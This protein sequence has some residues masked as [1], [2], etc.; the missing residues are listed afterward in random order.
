MIQPALIYL[1]KKRVRLNNSYENIFFFMCVKFSLLKLYNKHAMNLVNFQEKKLLKENEIDKKLIFEIINKCPSSF[2]LF[3]FF[4]QKFFLSQKLILRWNFFLAFF[5]VK[6]WGKKSFS[7]VFE[8]KLDKWEKPINSKRFLKIQNFSFD[9]Y[10][11]E[12]QLLN[13]NL[14]W[15]EKFPSSMKRPWPKHLNSIKM[16][17]LFAFQK[18]ISI[19]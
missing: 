17:R 5:F 15:Q 12:Q 19:L 2:F 1:V 4:N 9:A 8:K 13:T 10:E 11:R 18:G 16:S 3:Y 7:K 6:S 14:F